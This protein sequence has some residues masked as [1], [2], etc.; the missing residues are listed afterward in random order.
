MGI[1]ADQKISHCII[2][3]SSLNFDQLQLINMSECK[4]GGV[5]QRFID[6]IISVGQS[7][8]SRK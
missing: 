4:D 8:N 3:P 6:V 7:D 2:F 1:N 5:W